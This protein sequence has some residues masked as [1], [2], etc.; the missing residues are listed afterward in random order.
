MEIETPTI[1][2]R[3][4]RSHR[5]CK[6]VLDQLFCAS[7]VRIKRSP[8][9]FPTVA[10]PLSIPRDDM[11]SVRDRDQTVGRRRIEEES[12]HEKLAANS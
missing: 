1:H 6:H 10:P 12:L 2:S 7:L 8:S 3:G 9:R 4:F 5:F 11:N